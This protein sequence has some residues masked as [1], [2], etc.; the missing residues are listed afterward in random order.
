MARAQATDYLH[1]MKFHV[2]V[3][4]VGGTNMLRT[5]VS[6]GKP[7]AGF[8]ACTTPEATVEAVEYKE[9]QWVYT[10][11]YP[12]NPS[13]GDVTLSRGA[14]RADSSFW[15]WLKLVIEGGEYRADIQIKH[16]SRDKALPGQGPGAGNITSLD[17][18]QN[19]ARTYQVWEAFPMR[20]K[21]AADL[22]AT[23]SEISIMEIDCSYEYFDV[24][25][26]A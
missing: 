3:T 13:M 6:G 19:P 10:R 20:H 9:G 24:I 14:A 23:A 2:D 8:S 26:H 16:Y 1:S 4:R 17:L 7:Q 22:D 11:K 15:E 21:V 5:T 25:E 12:G 18:A